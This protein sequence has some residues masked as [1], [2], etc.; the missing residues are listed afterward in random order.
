MLAVEPDRAAAVDM[1]LD[2][3]PFIVRE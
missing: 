2:G 1:S 3:S